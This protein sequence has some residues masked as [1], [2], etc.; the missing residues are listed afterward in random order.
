[1]LAPKQQANKQQPSSLGDFQFPTAEEGRSIPVIMGTVKLQSPNVTWYGDLGTTE[2]SQRVKTGPCSSTNVT[3][4]YKYYVSMQLALALGAVDELSEIWVGDY[5]AWSGSCTNNGSFRTLYVNNPGLFGGDESEGGI[6]GNVTIFFGNSNQPI[7]PYYATVCANTGYHRYFYGGNTS[8]WDNLLNNAGFNKSVVPKFNGVCYAS[9]RQVYIGTSTYIKPWYFVMR[10]IPCSINGSAS[11]CNINGDA[12]PAEMIFE[13]LTNDEWGLGI[14][15]SLIDVQCFTTAAQT[16]K[17][18]GTGLSMQ[19]DAQTEAQD[20]IDEIARHIDASIFTDNGTGLVKI[21]LIRGDYDVSQILHLDQSS[22]KSLELSRIS[23]PET[24]NEVKVNYVDRAAG[25]VDKVAQAVDLANFRIQNGDLISQT[26]DFKGFSNATAAAQAS[27]RCLKVVSF[28]LAK[29]KLVTNRKAYGLVPGDVIAL[30]WEPLGIYE[31]VFRITAPNYGS[32]EDG[33]IE[34]D[35]IEDIYSMPSAVFVPP[36]GSGSIDP[37]NST[38]TDLTYKGIIET[39]YFYQGS[40]R[41]VSTIAVR[42]NPNYYQY[43]IWTTLRS[44]SYELTEIISAFTP[45]G[46]LLNDYNRNTAMD[47]SD[48]FII[49]PIADIE[50]LQSILLQDRIK[51]TCL[52]AIDSEI[53]AWATV[54]DLGDGTFK[55]KDILRGVMDTIPQKHIAGSVVY[56]ISHGAGLTSQT[57]LDNDVNFKVKFLPRNKKG[58][59]DISKASELSIT[60]QSRAFKPYPVGNLQVAGKLYPTVVSGSN[61]VVTWSHRNRL[62]QG[63]VNLM[64]Q[65]QGSVSGGPEGNYTITTLINGVQKAQIVGSTDTTLTITA[66]QRLTYSSDG[67]QLVKV[68]ITPVNGSLTGTNHDTEGFIMTGYG[69]TYGQFYGGV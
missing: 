26:F 66:A 53:M 37:I 50:R 16:L 43:E 23:W 42:N 68:V 27:V 59:L 19:F 17:N 34:L 61:V 29:I 20:I 65:D 36:P 67:T 1:M 22:I 56:F 46:I 6:Q 60:T 69:M 44:G 49:S 18:E 13:C 7:D 24:Y 32:V 11:Y 51:G 12:N 10:R 2:M 40:N 41:W 31:K 8:Y 21:K 48:G 9:L 5:K 4:G 64:S 45:A 38:P 33:E 28:P 63:Q 15:R 30:T 57:K 62:A 47:D 35:A 39:P 25:F 54:L 55:I 3:R 14:P 58:A 52:V